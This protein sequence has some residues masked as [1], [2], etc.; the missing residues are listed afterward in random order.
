LGRVHRLVS[1]TESGFSE[2][3]PAF[4]IIYLQ[5]TQLCVLLSIF[6]PAD[7][8]AHSFQ[9]TVFCSVY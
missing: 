1:W 8:N 5:R 7:G 6:S 2:T 3:G 4:E 9:N